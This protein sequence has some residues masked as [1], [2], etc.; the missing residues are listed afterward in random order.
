MALMRRARGR[1]SSAGQCHPMFRTLPQLLQLA[2]A[3]GAAPTG[4]LKINWRSLAPL[5]RFA[6]FDRASGFKRVCGRQPYIYARAHFVRTD[7]R[8][9]TMNVH[10]RRSRTR[11]GPCFLRGWCRSARRTPCLYMLMRS[12][13]NTATFTPMCPEMKGFECGITLMMM[14][15][16]GER[17]DQFCTCAALP[18][19]AALFT[20][21]PRPVIWWWGAQT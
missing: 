14:R 19:C 7:T 15:T 12:A 1:K 16:R 9:T 10:A 13:L 3:C 4:C 21:F 11:L 8:I 20:V 17:Q 18:R 2:V 6:P 5:R